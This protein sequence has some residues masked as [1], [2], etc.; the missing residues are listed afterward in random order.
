MTNKSET[1]GNQQ[2]VDYMNNLEHPFKKEIEEV[3][4]II[5]G[6]DNQLTE[7]I[8]WNAPSYCYN[9]EDRVT[10]NL[11]GKGYFRLIFHCGAKARDTIA[12]EPLFDDITGLLEWATGDRAI[13]KFTDMNDVNAKKEKLEILISKWIEATG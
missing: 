13:L 12:K 7:H 10:F 6:T 4:K 5:L 3:R 2:V 1:I 8:K 11:H 9:N